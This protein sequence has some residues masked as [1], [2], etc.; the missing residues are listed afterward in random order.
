M[1]EVRVKRNHLKSAREVV[2]QGHAL[3]APHGTDIVCAAVSVL[4]QTVALA[5]ED[6]LE[7]D[8][9][10]V[11]EEGFFSINAPESVEGDKKEKF[12]LLMDTMLL[13]LKETARS[14]PDHLVYREE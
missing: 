11:M 4:T 13:G 6:L 12:D 7:M 8:P 2:V 3:F 9:D 10:I 5:V 1:L 14:Y